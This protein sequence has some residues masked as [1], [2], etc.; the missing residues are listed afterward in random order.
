MLGPLQ[1]SGLIQPGLTFLEP[2]VTRT[3]N[4]R[5]NAQLQKM[6]PLEVTGLGL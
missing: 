3:K 1:K 6:K 4:T 5:A 2:T